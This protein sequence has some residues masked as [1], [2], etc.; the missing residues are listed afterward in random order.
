MVA[1]RTEPDDD[2]LVWRRFQAAEVHWCLTLIGGKENWH[3]LPGRR[4]VEDPRQVFVTALHPQPVEIGA[5]QLGA[6]RVVTTRCTTC[7]R[8]M[9]AW[10]ASGSVNV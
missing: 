10:Y 3:P 6:P 1:C 8:R 4:E 2:D 5:R 7:V 9:F